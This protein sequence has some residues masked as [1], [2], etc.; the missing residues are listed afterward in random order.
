MKKLALFGGAPLRQKPFPAYPVYG[1]E[2]EEAV[3]RVVRSNALCAQVGHEVELFEKEYAAYHDVPNA[4][5][6]TNGTIA[7]HIA[8]AA[9]GVGVGDE[10]IVPPYTWLSTGSAVIMQ[11]AIPVFA[12][13]EPDSIGLDPDAV[14][15]KITPCTKAII[16]VHVNGYP[17]DMDGL[18]KLAAERNLILIEDCAHAH[19]AEYHGKKVGTLG[20]FGCFSFQ[21]KKNLSLGEGG[22]VITS[23]TELAGRLKALRSFE[24][25][26]I[27]YNY[28]LPELQAAIGRVRL[29]KLDQMN[30]ARRKN[31][32]VLDRELKGI[33]GLIPQQV[34]ENCM[35]VF[36]NYAIKYSEKELGVPRDRF[37]EAAVAEGIGSIGFYRPINNDPIFKLQD[38]FGHGCPFR[39]PLYKGT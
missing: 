4:V 15:K 2:E 12:D 6:V 17:C 34:R 13:I 39:C 36:Y 18:L 28:R 31:A 29:Q 10:V 37:I 24:Y 21:H 35:G 22:M 5:A 1:W 8:L 27:N 33:R 11:N 16:T 3:V 7:L 30:E 14:V 26:N 23:N 32:A 9:A 25:P 38:A 19:G 20:Q